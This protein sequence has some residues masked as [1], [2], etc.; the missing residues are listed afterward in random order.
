RQLTQPGTHPPAAAAVATGIEQAAHAASRSWQSWRALAHDW[1][2]FT[3]NRGTA[4]TPVAAEIGDLTLWTGRLAHT[5]PAWT[6]ARAHALFPLAPFSP[7]AATRTPA[8]PPPRPPPTAPPPRTAPHNRKTP[9]SPPKTDQIPAPPRLLQ[10]D[11]DFPYRYV[12]PPP[13][14]LDELLAT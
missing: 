3:T 13:A 12:P 6:P 8:V 11:D 1:D 14:M 2:T 9:P 10:E 5:D 4:F 7:A